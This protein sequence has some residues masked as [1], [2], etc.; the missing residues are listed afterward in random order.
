MRYPDTR[1][2]NSTPSDPPMNTELS[3][4]ITYRE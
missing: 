1:K 2:K 3:Y 4:P